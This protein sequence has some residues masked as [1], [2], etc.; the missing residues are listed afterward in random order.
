MPV[1]S[2]FDEDLIRNEGTTLGTT[3]APLVKG[4]S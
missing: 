4:D 2:K 1:I 3:F